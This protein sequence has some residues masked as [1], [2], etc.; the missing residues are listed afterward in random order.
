MLA[1]A[2]AGVR[3]EA[4]I[5]TEAGHG[6]LNRNPHFTLTLVEADR[7][8]TSLGRLSGRLGILCAAVTHL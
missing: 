4:R 1:V 7:F 2:I 6:F 5:Y 3:G 8:L